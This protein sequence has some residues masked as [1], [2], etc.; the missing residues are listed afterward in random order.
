[1]GD[2]KVPFPTEGLEDAL[3]ILS[4]GLQTM[5]LSETV[6]VDRAR[7]LYL[8]HRGALE[9]HGLHEQLKSVAVQEYD[10]IYAVVGVV[11]TKARIFSQAGNSLPCSNMEGFSNEG[12]LFFWATVV[13][14]V[15]PSA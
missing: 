11:V 10:R 9:D 4:Q 3:K 5:G 6:R 8:D 7:V 12:E 1:M 2:P 14:D 13:V 15:Y